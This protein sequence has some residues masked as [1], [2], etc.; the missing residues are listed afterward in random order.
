MQLHEASTKGGMEALPSLRD[1]GIR[2][3]G[4]MEHTHY[5]IRLF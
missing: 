3:A 1:L 5:H 2:Y 4:G